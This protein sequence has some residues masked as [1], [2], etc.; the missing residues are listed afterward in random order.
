MLNRFWVKSGALS[1]KMHLVLPN[2]HWFWRHFYFDF[3]IILLEH[4]AFSSM[5]S[6]FDVILLV[7]IR[8]LV[9]IY[10]IQHICISI[11]IKASHNVDYS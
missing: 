5:R 1:L 10:S 2:C 6:F 9:S 11:R 7:P 4:G 3:F 8:R